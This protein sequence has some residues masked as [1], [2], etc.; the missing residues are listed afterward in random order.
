M[1][2]NALYYPHIGLHDSSWIK[3]KSLFYDNIYRI[4][5]DNVIPD[6][7]EELHA[8]LEE[9]SVGRMTDPAMLPSRRMIVGVLH[10]ED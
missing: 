3:S 10:N 1:E 2:Q 6:N 4:A 5:P 9:G 7:S 8:L